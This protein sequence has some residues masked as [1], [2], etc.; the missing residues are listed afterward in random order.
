MSARTHKHTGTHLHEQIRFQLSHSL[1]M[2]ELESGKER[3]TKCALLYI[4]LSSSQI[5]WLCLALALPRSL[6]RVSA[7]SVYRTLSLSFT[8]SK[9]FCLKISLSIC[10]SLRVS[11][12]LSLLQSRVS[13]PQ[14]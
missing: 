7:L 6:S 4:A 9:T 1:E 5:L 10:V 11:Q 3:Y 8:L 2:G 13:Q 14:G 12:F